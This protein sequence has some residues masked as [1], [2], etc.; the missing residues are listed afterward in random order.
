MAETQ[1]QV[2]H[3]GIATLMLSLKQTPLTFYGGKMVDHLK[4]NR[5]DQYVSICEL[6]TYF[7]VNQVDF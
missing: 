7:A 4:W 3:T 5:M 2:V 6:I 1:R